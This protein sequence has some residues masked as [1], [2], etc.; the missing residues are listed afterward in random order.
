MWI[1]PTYR[2]PDKCNDVLKCIIAVGCT[3][4][5]IVIV[6]GMDDYIEYQKI[7][8]PKD[9]Q[10]IFLPQNIGCCGAM[11]W[12]FN[13]YPNEPFYG[14]LCDDELIYSTDWDKTLT[15]AAGSKYMAHAND[16]WQSGKRPHCYVTWGGDLIR[17]VG[18][19]SLP[20]LWHWYHENAWEMLA[21]GLP[22]IR[23][24]QDVRGEH[25]HY[26]AG[27]AEKD[28]TYQAG[29]SR[30]GNDQMIFQ[31]WVITQYPIL[32]RKLA[33]FYDKDKTDGQQN[34]SL[35]QTGKKADEPPRPS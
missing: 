6:N 10:M 12:A 23:F 4:P 21:S 9:W 20:G 25:K 13:K 31:N 19:M 22:M 11:N 28:Y 32:K 17:E 18:W 33:L 29:E 5:G 26:L 24:C 30:N 27:K 7:E 8:L 2:R 1:L 35:D 3:T 14:L 16:G 15:A 34:Q